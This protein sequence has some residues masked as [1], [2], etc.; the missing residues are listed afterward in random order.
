MRDHLPDTVIF[1]STDEG[2]AIFE[3]HG[4][5]GWWTMRIRKFYTGGRKFRRFAKIQVRQ[6]KAS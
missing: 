2:V 3:S 1:V 6:Q 5:P 4:Y